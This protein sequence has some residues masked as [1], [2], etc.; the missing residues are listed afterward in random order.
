MAEVERA[1][2]PNNI[3]VG[4]RYVPIYEGEWVQTKAYESLVIVTHNN[5]TYISNSPVPANTEI[6]NTTY[7][8]KMYGGNQQLEDVH[9]L[10][11]GFQT[12][13]DNMND[14]LDE[15]GQGG[16]VWK[17]ALAY[18]MAPGTDIT[19]RLEQLGSGDNIGFSAGTYTI[20]RPLNI[21]A[22]CYFAPGAVLKSSSDLRFLKDVIAGPWQIFNIGNPAS[23]IKYI[24][25]NREI[26]PEW[27]GASENGVNDTSYFFEAALN[28]QHP[29]KTLLLGSGAYPINRTIT[30][31][32]STH[33]KGNG[34]VIEFGSEGAIKISGSPTPQ[35]QTIIERIS[36]TSEN[37]NPVIHVTSTQSQVI[38]RNCS[39]TGNFLFVNAETGVSNEQNNEIIF[40]NDFI[41][42]ET[43]TLSSLSH[44][45]ENVSNQWTISVKECIFSNSSNTMLLSSDTISALKSDVYL[46]RCIT[47]SSPTIYSYGNLHIIN[48]F[49]TTV[50]GT[51]FIGKDTD[52][53]LD[54]SNGSTVTFEASHCNLSMGGPGITI[55]LGGCGDIMSCNLKGTQPF[56]FQAL[57]KGSRVIISKTFINSEGTVNLTGTNGWDKG[58]LITDCNFGSDRVIN[59]PSTFVF[60]NSPWGNSSSIT[61]KKLLNQYYIIPGQISGYQPNSTSREYLGYKPSIRAK[62]L[63][64]IVIEGYIPYSRITELSNYKENNEYVLRADPEFRIT[65]FNDA[66]GVSYS[67]QFNLE[68]IEYFRESSGYITDLIKLT[69][70]GE[71]IEL[72]S[73]YTAFM[74]NEIKISVKT[75]STGSLVIGTFYAHLALLI[76]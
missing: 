71:S 29:N 44:D 35:P 58:V 18:N 34:C 8:A 70:T 65:S 1:V 63:N 56:N 75:T 27:Y 59:S 46:Y 68:S 19:D 49:P 39:I 5:D 37:I 48:N 26:R 38:I 41:T 67:A 31:P 32:Y 7:W 47:S 42:G 57:T 76:T 33:L 62:T 74:N 50:R 36:F 11:E 61:A 6:T 3:Y 72:R 66:V 2:N 17:P 15:L 53:T 54:A 25:S 9:T 13:L 22:R 12:Q 43:V 73:N 69:Y 52:I 28:G 21:T 60:N 30:L 40:D 23:P 20:S 24:L 64:K 55:D 4:M 16:Y 45:L 51:H 14:K 10:V